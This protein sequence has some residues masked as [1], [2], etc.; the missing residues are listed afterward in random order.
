MLVAI[1]PVRLCRRAA[2]SESRGRSAYSLY[3]TES[4]RLST[5]KVD[6]TAPIR[7][8]LQIFME[9]ALVNHPGENPSSHTAGVFI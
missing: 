2:V 3:F 1:R 5:E 9:T 8:L 7:A 4:V 6:G